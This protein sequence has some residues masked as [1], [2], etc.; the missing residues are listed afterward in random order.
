MLC[1]VIT[2]VIITLYMLLYTGNVPVC[3]ANINH[4]IMTIDVR[5]RILNIQ[6]D[7]D[8]IHTHTEC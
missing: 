4:K 7:C 5:Q 2:G 8:Y 6:V 3:L 1:G